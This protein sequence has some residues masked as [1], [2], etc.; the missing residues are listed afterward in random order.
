MTRSTFCLCIALLLASADAPVAGLQRG[1][2]DTGPGTTAAARRHLEGRWSLVSFDVYTPGQPTLRLTGQGVLTYDN[3]GNLEV[4]IR[5]DTAT[6]TRLVGA[7]IPVTH[8][9]I[10]TSGRTAI[11]LQQRTLTYFLEGQPPFG[12]PS[13]PLA[14]NR[15]RHWEVEGDTLTLTTRGADGQPLSIARW[16]KVR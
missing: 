14:L 10:S 15:P 4:E 2:V 8:G 6:A 12:S 13:G 11:D 7:G 9:V 5:V 3:F 16:E 1:P